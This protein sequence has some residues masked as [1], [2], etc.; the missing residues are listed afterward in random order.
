M[1]CSTARRLLL[2]TVSM[3]LTP[4]FAVAQ[5]RFTD[6]TGLRGIGSYSG[7]AMG[8]GIAAADFDDDGDIDIFVPNHGAP[9][10]LYRN[11]GTGQFE[12]IATAA[13]LDSSAHNRIALWFDYDG[14]HDLDLVVAGDCF[15]LP[16]EGQAHLK[17]Y[18]QD[19]MAQFVDVTSQAE[20]PVLLAGSPVHVGGLSAGD[21]NEDGYLDLLVATWEGRDTLF[22]NDG[23]GTFSDI[24]VSAGLGGPGTHWQPMM[25]DFD[26]DGWLDIM[27]AVDFDANRLWIN[28]QDNTFLD[29]AAV[30]GADNAMNDMGLTLGDYDGDGD[31]DGY[32]SNVFKDG[33]HNILL[34]NDSV[35][36]SVSFVEV[37]QSAGVDDGFWG[38][39][40]TFFDADNDTLLDVAATNGFATE[41]WTTDPSRFF[42]NQGG[43]PVTF[44]EVSDAANFDD[45]FWG[46]SL[47]TLDSD[48]DGDLD[49]LQTCVEGGRLRLLENA[50]A[51]EVAN[52]YLVIR[53]R[54]TGPN[55]HAIGAVVHVTLGSTSMMRLIS[56]G[57]SFMGQEPAEAF[58]GTMNAATVDKV[59]IDWPDGTETTIAGVPVNLVL[60]VTNEAAPI[61]GSDTDCDD[62]RFCNGPESCVSGYC[63]RFTPSCNDLDACTVD[64]CDE[65]LD[66]CTS[67]QLTGPDEVANLRLLAGPPGSPDANLM[68]GHTELASS[69]N[70][71]RSTA[72]DLAD[73]SCLVSHLPGTSS[74]DDTPPSIGQFFYYLV[75]AANCAGESGLGAGRINLAPC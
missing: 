25:H 28:Q 11:L 44:A 74:P 17:L 24:T 48:R 13:G 65:A 51:V 12:E 62:G 20:L 39:G 4:P 64:I 3:T 8:G 23:D 34:R 27:Q 5:V 61:C 68:W 50:P 43:S 29:L 52:T 21:I 6:A 22:L 30:A 66:Q 60:T 56:A 26:G 31:L 1:R 72:I 40:V 71:Y 57:T 32:I 42:L 45:R 9:D 33:K 46:S 70:V 18:R 41:P 75:T 54:M 35:G 73:L 2:L 14:D 49:M 10:Q 58:F 55:Y 69:Y 67:T 7:A 19:S 36:T 15:G 59:T 63:A 16:C 53:P 37:A 47:I 38:W